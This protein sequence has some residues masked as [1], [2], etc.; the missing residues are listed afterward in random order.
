MKALF[1]GIVL[2]FAAFSA[3]AGGFYPD[4][5]SGIDHKHPSCYNRPVQVQ[6]HHYHQRPQYYNHHNHYRH[7]PVYIDR[8]N[9]WV[10]PLVGGVILGA[11]INS[12]ADRVER[13]ERV[14]RIENVCSEWREIMQPNGTIV[15]ERTCYNR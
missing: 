8:R 2:S 9:D 14:E 11:V 15:R 10:A 3:N 13:V 6:H 12:A 4:C 7:A 1:A 5:R